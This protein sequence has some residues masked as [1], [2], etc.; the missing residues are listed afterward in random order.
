MTDWDQRWRERETPWDKGEPAPA[1]LEAL[2]HPEDGEFLAGARVLVPGC[3]SGHDVRALAAAGAQVTGLDLSPTAVE[4]ARQHPRVNGET[5]VC[6]SLFDWEAEPFDAVWEHTCFCAI[7]PSTRELYALAVGRLVRPGGRLIGVFYPDPEDPDDDPPYPV[8][9][10]E[11]VR[12][13]K[14]WFTLVRGSKPKE[15]FPSRVG[16][17]WLAAFVRHDD[18]RRVAVDGLAV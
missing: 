7:H 5:Y 18:E 3:G 1:L 17:E 2:A 4:V 6:A 16:R 8:E 15:S 9:T 13:L 12:H 11:I 10:D 14:R